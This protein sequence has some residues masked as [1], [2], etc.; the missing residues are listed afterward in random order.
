MAPKGSE[1]QT[2][3]FTDGYAP[4]E[5]VM[6]RAETRSD[7]YALAATLY[8]LATDDDPRT[9]PFAFPQL[10]QLGLLGDILQDALA[11][12]IDRR[13]TAAVLCRRL[14]S[15]I[16]P[17]AAPVLQAPDGAA[18]DDLPAL[19][20]WCE[21][22]WWRTDQWL[23]YGGLPDQLE[24][25]WGK[26]RLAEELRDLRRWSAEVGSAVDQ[27]LALLDPHGFGQTSPQLAVDLPA[28]DFGAQPGRPGGDVTLTITN[29]GRR[30]V[31]ATLELP[32]WLDADRLAIALAPGRQIAITL[33]V[34]PRGVWARGRR[35]AVR[36]LTGS[37]LQQRYPGALTP[38]VIVPV[39]AAAPFWRALFGRASR[40]VP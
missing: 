10:A 7:L 25:R 27:L 21:A 9:H 19:I 2:I 31:R 33:A 32:A 30:Y 13:P 24:R 5:Q 15:A 11:L 29:S 8:H 4:P 38:L 18:I 3:V 39:R 35:G 26:T 34:K 16:L 1:R 14:E 40:G 20:R 23:R 12:Q 17:M 36:I 6:G 37:D 22:D 28:I